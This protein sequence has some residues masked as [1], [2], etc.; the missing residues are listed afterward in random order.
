MPTPLGT[1]LLQAISFVSV[2]PPSHSAAK[3]Q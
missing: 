1:G 3:T 2:A